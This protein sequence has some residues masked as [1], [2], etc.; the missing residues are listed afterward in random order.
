MRRALRLAAWNVGLALAALVLIAAGGEAWLRLTKPFMRNAVPMR[1]EPRVGL[2][3]EPGAEVRRTNLRD[4]WTASR[5]NRWG[6][7]DREPLPPDRAA[8]S[9]HVS[10][11][12]D[13]FVD[14]MQV[15]IAAKLHVRLE[16]LAARRLPHLDVT[17]SAFGM[18]DT[19]QI[20]QLP[21]YD[22]YARR[23][24]PKLLV[25]VFFHNDFWNNSPVLTAL[26]RGL[27][28]DRLPQA[29]IVRGADGALTL[30]PPD[31]E[32]WKHSLPLNIRPAPTTPF[33]RIVR[34]ATRRSWFARWLALRPDPGRR[35]SHVAEG[36][37][38]ELLSRRPGYER[39]VGER[40]AAIADHR[41]AL[42]EDVLSPVFEQAVAY[43]GFAL[44]LFKA[45]ADRDGAALVILTTHSLGKQ[46]DPVFD[47]LHGLAAARG[48]PA[49]SQYAW[50]ERQ[51]GDARDAR[52]PHDPHWSPTGHQW[53][54]EALLEH[55][56]QN[57]DIC[58]GTS[59]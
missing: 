2:V 51:G 44:D 59:W 34:R 48:I 47:R 39:L 14:A 50:I 7:L 42:E 27:D 1:F 26:R 11:I 19:G 23:L 13:S 29:S 55:L 36:K 49:I 17:T 52:W 37:A 40:P 57:Q 56:A 58:R 54:A 35:R 31:P 53:A 38:L 20:A 12:G 28:P 33:D 21:F 8:A 32:Y 15:P 41:A 6:F 43:T 45:R 16:A 10:V 5:A 18:F 25:L 24:H 3:H 22:T 4:F 30:R 9:C 46:G